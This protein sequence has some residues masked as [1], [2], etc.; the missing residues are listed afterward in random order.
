M[1]MSRVSERGDAA[2]GEVEVSEEVCFAGRLQRLV[3]G[4]SFAWLMAANLVGLLLSVMLL[5][6]TWWEPFGGFTY[7]RWMPLHMDWHLYGWCAL[8]LVGLLMRFML[9]S[10]LAALRHA[11]A[12][13]V[14]WSGA[15]LLLG[16][17]CL[18]GEGSGKLFLEWKAASRV[19]FPAAQVFLWVIL[20]GHFVSRYRL[21]GR[22]LRLDYLRLAVA[23]L[24][25]ASPV[26]LFVTSGA[27]VYPPI[28]PESGGATGHSLLASSLGIIVLFGLM[29]HLLGVAGRSKNS[30][31]RRVYWLAMGLSV[32]AWVAIDHGN[33]SNTQVGQML[34]LAV[35][36]G[37]IPLVWRYYAMHD[38]GTAERPW[39][40][41]FVF[42]WALLTVNG[43]ISF[44]PPVLAIVK[45][46]NAM[47]AH[48]HLAMAGMLSSFNML[49]LSAMG[50]RQQKKGPWGDI[51]AFAG[52]QVGTLIYVL[53]M[54]LQ[55]VREGLDPF[56]LVADDPLTQFLYAIRLLAGIF[57][58]AASARWLWLSRMGAGVL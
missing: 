18:A 57:M 47:V 1:P 19:A 4:Y 5:R 36:L 35:L 53:V 10:G 44:L 16:L 28:D 15:L 22:L 43:F 54:T 20:A 13:L 17:M 8:P 25:I 56:V 37:W 42:W 33:A 24:A 58:I 21:Q 50:T 11:H 29:P 26:A 46:T 48:A 32:L 30:L 39:V 34:G 9:P 3:A 55:G 31:S 52:W 27:E 49:V 14:V 45:F 7:G 6:P 38:W 2:S 23:L 51:P 41:A 12:A 40:L